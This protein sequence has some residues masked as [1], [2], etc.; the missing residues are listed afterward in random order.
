MSR[1]GVQLVPQRLRVH[2]QAGAR[3]L[4]HL[5]RQGQVVGVL[6]DGRRHRKLHRVAPARYQLPR[7]E[8]RLDALAAPA[9]V[10]LPPVAHD[11]KRALDHVDLLGLLE[12]PVPRRELAPALRTR[13]VRLVEHVHDVDHRQLGLLAPAVPR[14]LSRPLRFAR[15]APRAPFGRR[16]EDLAIARFELLLQKRQLL[17]DRQNRVLA[18][19][20]GELLGDL[21]QALV[22][23]CILHLLREGD[24]AQAL[25]VALG[26]DPDHDKPLTSA[27]FSRQI[28]KHTFS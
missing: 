25:D 19:R 23:P 27:K 16:P 24:L 4:L 12:V 2:D 9:R 18:A 3:H 6:R 7:P 5:A 1:K 13:R 15:R 10:L 26:L 22:Q 11:A 20:H 21:E 8:C 14:A 17:L 28:R